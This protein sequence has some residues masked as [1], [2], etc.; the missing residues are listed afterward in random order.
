M[1]SVDLVIFFRL[2]AQNLGVFFCPQFNQ[3]L[4]IEYGNFVITEPESVLL[5]IEPADHFRKQFIYFLR[6]QAN[7]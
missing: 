3:R 5:I 7:G 2:Q 4:G 6:N 1:Q